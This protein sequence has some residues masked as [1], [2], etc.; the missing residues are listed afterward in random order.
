MRA[1]RVAEQGAVV[2]EDVSVAVAEGEEEARGAFDV[3]EDEDDGALGQLS[4]AASPCTAC[5]N[6]TPPGASA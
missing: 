5:G 1:E 6:A 4:H 2:V 3:G